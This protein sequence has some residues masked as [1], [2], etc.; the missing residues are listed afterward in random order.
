MSDSLQPHGL[1]PTRLLCPWDFPG[2]NTGVGSHFLLQGIFLT[3]GSNSRLLHCRQTLYRLSHLGSLKIFYHGTGYIFLRQRQLGPQ[4]KV[5][6]DSFLG[7]PKNTI[8]TSRWTSKHKP[9]F[10]GHVA[11]IQCNY[12]NSCRYHFRRN[13]DV[14]RIVK[15]ERTLKDGLF[16]PLR[17]VSHASSVLGFEGGGSL[18]PLPTSFFL[19]SRFK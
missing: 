5:I 6:G 11:R 10:P 14:Y 16:Q 1:Q 8:N 3:Q 17:C 7:D 19:V 13:L 4:R 12:R 18:S 9:L 2:K 15:L